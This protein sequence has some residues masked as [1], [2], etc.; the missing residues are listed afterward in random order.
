MSIIM[1]T[2][3]WIS[4]FSLEKI[5]FLITSNLFLNKNWFNPIDLDAFSESISRKKTAKKNPKMYFN[6]Y[7]NIFWIWNKVYWSELDLS[8]ETFLIQNFP[9]NR[10]LWW[11]NCWKWPKLLRSR[12]VQV[13]KLSI[14][15]FN[16]TN[17][18]HIWRL[19]QNFNSLSCI[20]SEK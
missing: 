19:C 16:S 12:K 18:R 5:C 11:K 14:P 2:I 8:V 13:S 10:K 1:N 4:Y 3:T 9:F 15:T 17:C 20:L 6:R 7:K